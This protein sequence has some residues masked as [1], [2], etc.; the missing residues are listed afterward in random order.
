MLTLTTKEIAA[1]FLAPFVEEQHT[2][3]YK[4]P[5][6]T[7]GKAWGAGRL[8]QQAWVPGEIRRKLDIWEW[9]VL[10]NPT[11][12]RSGA[13]NTK[14]QAIK[15]LTKEAIT[16]LPP[17]WGFSLDNAYFAVHAIPA[18]IVNSSEFNPFGLL[19]LP[20]RVREVIWNKLGDKIPA[21]I[22]PHCR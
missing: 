22:K 14:E 2:V 19:S 7:I 9:K 21:H 11:W 10:R 18:E 12:N 5:G 16:A 1:E 8:S 4:A 13:V 6:R 15:A 17:A 3:F 20:V